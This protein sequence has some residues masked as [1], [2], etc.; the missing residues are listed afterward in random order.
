MGD[1]ELVEFA[2]A[3]DA[4]TCAIE[5][6]RQI[7]ERNVGG[8]EKTIESSSGSASMSGTSSSTAKISTVMA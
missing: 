6:Q 3:V 8:P 5:V 1:G 4:V 7:R 2:S